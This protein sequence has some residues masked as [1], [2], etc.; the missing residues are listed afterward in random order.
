MT[1][2][3]VSWVST[4]EILTTE[5]RTTGHSAANAI[6]RIGAIFSP[7]VIEG[8]SLFDPIGVQR[9]LDCCVSVPGEST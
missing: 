6:A 5:V 9:V 7:F 3:C 8:S 1:G 2:S 4:A